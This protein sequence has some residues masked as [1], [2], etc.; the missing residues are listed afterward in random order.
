MIIIISV[1]NIKKLKSTDL[2]SFGKENLINIKDVNID[3]DTP[4]QQ[5]IEKYLNDIKHPY[6]FISGDLI[7]HIEYV[8]KNI[9]LQQK[10]E[11]IFK[12]Q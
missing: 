4:K 5:R 9:S 7:V 2:N 10:I 11:K 8:E 12:L 3:I 1:N 6:L